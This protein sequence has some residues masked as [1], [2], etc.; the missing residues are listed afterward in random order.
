M[1]KVARCHP[2]SLVQSPNPPGMS[3]EVKMMPTS[4][5][6]FSKMGGRTTT[7]LVIT[8]FSFIFMLQQVL[9]DVP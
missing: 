7:N 1:L 4:I 6:I 5:D 8:K 3:W 9:T 2:V